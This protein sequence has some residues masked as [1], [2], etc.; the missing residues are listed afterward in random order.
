MNCK[1]TI[2]NI[3]NN[4]KGFR[5]KSINNIYKIQ[6]NSEIKHA[7]DTQIEIDWINNESQ[8]EVKTGLKKS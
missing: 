6:A 4:L 8:S 7:Q 2:M 5:N 3:S 1:I